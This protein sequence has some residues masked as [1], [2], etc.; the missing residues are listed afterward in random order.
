[1]L[2]NFRIGNENIIAFAQGLQRLPD[3]HVAITE[4]H[5]Q[6]C[7]LI[8]ER[9]RDLVAPEQ[10]Q[11]RHSLPSIVADPGAPSVV[12]SGITAVTNAVDRM[13]SLR[14]LDLSKNRIGQEGGAALAQSLSHHKCIED[15]RLA[16]CKLSDKVAGGILNA[17]VAHPT[18]T[19]LDLGSNQVGG[20][21]VCFEPLAL[22]LAAPQGK[23][24]TLEFAWNSVGGLGMAAISA[25][26]KENV[27]LTTLNMAWNAL[28]DQGAMLLASSLRYNAALTSINVAHNDIKERGGMVFG[29]SLKENRAIQHIDFSENPLGIRGGRSV[30]RGLRWMCL[31]GIRRAMLFGRC[32]FSLEERCEELF[33]PAEP[34]GTWHCDLGNPYER[35]VANELV[36]LAWTQPGENWKNETLDGAPYQLPE[37]GPDEMWTRDDWKL[38]EAG[39]LQVTYQSTARVPRMRDVLSAAT[40]FE[41]V[42]LVKSQDT[43]DQSQRLIRLAAREFWFTA[44]H[45][46]TLMT[47][48]T[49]SAIRVDL[50]AVL[51]P[52]T[53]DMCQATTQLTNRLTDM[54]MTQLETKMGNLFNFSP[55]SASGHYRLNMSSAVDHSTL[56]KLME[57]SREEREYR[58]VYM[59]EHGTQNSI[60]TSEK[61]DWDGYRNER[62]D[63]HHGEGWEP[64]DFNERRPPSHGTVD[65]DFVSTGVA[66]RVTNTP[67]VPDIVFKWLVLDLLRIHH[68]V[69]ASRQDLE[70]RLHADTS[71]SG[72]RRRSKRQP[73]KVVGAENR[74][75]PSAHEQQAAA[76][77]LQRVFRGWRARFGQVYERVSTLARAA[78]EADERRRGW[79]RLLLREWRGIPLEGLDRAAQVFQALWRGRCSRL[80]VRRMRQADMEALL[81]SRGAS[82]ALR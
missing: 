33:D 11:A 80:V 70:S 17:L 72:R 66:H 41:F 42:R 25:S 15:V 75:A 55:R 2:N 82:T 62:I 27:T 21:P 14:V 81:Q 4:V 35:V 23:L 57:I 18:L 29:D 5:M 73:S 6:A 50:A 71:G 32:N 26:L 53:V 12:L 34:S 77:T 10:L 1:M 38:P 68:S 65:F 69:R 30:L 36:E 47:M 67:P 8:D 44:E 46:A 74:A 3:A 40:F 79:Q 45:S 37:P 31:L 59:L 22:L 49:E 39:V 43:N 78:V 54:E 76:V 24:S 52:R 28:Q 20:T 13:C 16:S 19:R 51:L 48:F 61:G 64:C 9:R 58:R 56:R 7:A 63:R 60:N